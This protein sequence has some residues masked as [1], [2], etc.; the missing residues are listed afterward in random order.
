MHRGVSIQADKIP[1]TDRQAVYAGVPAVRHRPVPC[2]CCCQAWVGPETQGQG[3][4][5]T[6]WKHSPQQRCP[7]RCS[8]LR[9]RRSQRL[10]ARSAS[11]PMHTQQPCRGRTM[12]RETLCL[13]F[14]ISSTRCQYAGPT[15]LTA[16]CASSAEPKVPIK[17]PS[18]SYASNVFGPT[19]LTPER[20]HGSTARP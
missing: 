17:F 15:S 4:C 20:T 9:S 6:R 13:C 16:C 8:W 18:G 12:L 19:C 14:N 2:C 3:R 7:P 10:S 5:W 1:L 11:P